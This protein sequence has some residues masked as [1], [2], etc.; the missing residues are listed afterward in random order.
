M[1]TTLEDLQ[2]RVE[3]VETETQRLA[4]L[5]EDPEQVDKPPTDGSLDQWLAR[6]RAKKARRGSFEDLLRSLGLPPDLKPIGA[7]AVQAM[8]LA[9]GVRPEDRLLSSEIIRLREETRP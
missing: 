6:L 1:S 4:R 2:R 3:A 5:V 8:M 9:D 7:E